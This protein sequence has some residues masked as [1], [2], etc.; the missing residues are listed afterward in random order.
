MI[1]D[2]LDFSYGNDVSLKYGCAV[3]LKG[4]MWYF[5]GSQSRQVSFKANQQVQINYS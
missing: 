1:N 3:T 5:G 4:V 2:D